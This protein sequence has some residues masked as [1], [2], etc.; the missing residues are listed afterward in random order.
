[1]CVSQWFLANSGSFSLIA[2]PAL[3][4]LFEAFCV[5]AGFARANCVAMTASQTVRIEKAPPAKAKFKTGVMLAARAAQRKQ[6][7]SGRFAALR[8]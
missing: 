6:Q 7:G 1:L 5:N 2:L 8:C 4:E 3:V